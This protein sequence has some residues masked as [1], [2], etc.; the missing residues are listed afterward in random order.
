MPSG[1]RPAAVHDLRRAAGERA[2]GERREGRVRARRRRRA[3]AEP[4]T[5]RRRGGA[6]RAR[7]GRPRSG[8][9]PR[10]PA[11]RAGSIAAP[12]AR[13]QRSPRAAAPSRRAPAA[14]G[15][16]RQPLM[17]RITSRKSAAT[18]AP[19]TSSSAA[20]APQVRPLQ[21]PDSAGVRAARGGRA[22][23][24]Q[25]E[26][27]LDDEDR[28]P[29]EQLRQ[30]PADRGPERGAEDPGERPDPRRRSVRSR[31]GGEQPERGADDGRA[32]DALNGACADERR[33]TTARAR[34][35]A[36]R[37]RRRPLRPRRP[38][39]GGDARRTPPAA[40]RARAPG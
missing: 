18:S 2:L 23:V 32:R 9:R 4:S 28:L 27:R 37:P 40:P 39:P 19:E 22:S 15:S 33:R 25:E 34:R 14:S 16:S 36:R 13:G 24:E 1:K 21:R 11:P 20:F 38:A 12:E 7:Q 31:R 3:A 29:A 6:S 5:R 26:G 17:S 8:S 10:P 35:R 30:D